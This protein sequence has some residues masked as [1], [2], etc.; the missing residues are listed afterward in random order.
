MKWHPLPNQE[1][2]EAA[3]GGCKCGLDGGE[4]AVVEGVLQGGG[5]STTVPP[6]VGGGRPLIG[7]GCGWGAV[8][9]VDNGVEA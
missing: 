4:V 2:R 6:P 5:I 8:R 1:N 9:R 3:D 7:R